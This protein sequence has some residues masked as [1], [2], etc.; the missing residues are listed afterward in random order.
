MKIFKKQYDLFK[1]ELK[2]YQKNIE[3]LERD[4]IAQVNKVFDKPLSENE[5]TFQE[6]IITGFER[7][8][9]ASMIY[10]VNKSI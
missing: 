1:D 8:K 2:A 3:S 9:L 5:M 4:H 10:G 7:V 6:F